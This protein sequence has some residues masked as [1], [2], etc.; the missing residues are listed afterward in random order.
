ML[1]GI[2]QTTGAS[3]ELSP[4]HA[5]ECNLTAAGTMEQHSRALSVI[6]AALLGRDVEDDLGRKVDQPR[7]RL[8]RLA[9]R[10]GL[11]LHVVFI[12]CM[13]SMATYPSFA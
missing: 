3:T 7:A 11:A 2:Q 13:R 8:D 9:H 4:W 6:R 5:P 10:N 12:L 1:K